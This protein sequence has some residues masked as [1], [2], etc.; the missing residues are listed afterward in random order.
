M[1]YKKDGQKWKEITKYRKSYLRKIHGFNRAL[2]SWSQRSEVDQNI[3]FR[4][5]PNGVPHI[6]VQRDKN[7]FMAPV[8]LLLMISSKRVSHS[9]N[10]W[11]RAPTYKVKIKHPLD[12]TS[13]HPPNN[14]FCVFSKE[15]IGRLLLVCSRAIHG[16]RAL[17]RSGAT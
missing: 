10:R 13:L 11:L 9:N 14:C 4:V 3:S 17:L 12:G 7:F 5:F 8:E 2:I 6:F 16:G 1:L 15:G